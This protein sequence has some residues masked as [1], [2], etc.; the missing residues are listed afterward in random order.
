MF[1][2][3]TS[4][5]AAV[6]F[7]SAASAGATFGF[8]NITGNNAGDAA[9]GEAQF[10]VTVIEESAGFVQ[11][12]FMNS[13]PEDSSLVQL[14][15]EDTTNLLS[16]ITGWSTTSSGVDFSGGSAKPGHLPGSSP[17]INDFSI[18][19]A[20]KGGKSKNGVGAG[21]DVTVRFTSD[22][23][24][25]YSKVVEAIESGELIIGTHAQAFVSGGSES[26]ITG[27]PHTAVPSPTAA[28][29]GLGLLGL[30][31]ARRRRR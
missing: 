31:A 26:F 24:N 13:G 28:L 14:Y 22:V 4:F 16:S 17:K 21:E 30:I 5:V 1:K 23:D 25:Y 7:A 18:Q 12:K 8:T 20:S 9:I 27:T 15:W 6:A 2:K 11:F 19:A 29:A 3:I 10:S